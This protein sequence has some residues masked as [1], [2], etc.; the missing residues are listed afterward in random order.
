MAFT[1]DTI[2]SAILRSPWLK[3]VA[4]LLAGG[5]VYL[6]AELSH[7]RIHERLQA[8]DEVLDRRKAERDSLT[9][10]LRYVRRLDSSLREVADRQRDFFCADR[11]RFC[12]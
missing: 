6:R 3:V 9:E 1:S 12:R 7:D 10:V 4:V 2:L 8:Q 11:P 5:A